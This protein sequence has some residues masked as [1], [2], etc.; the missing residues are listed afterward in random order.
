[1]EIDLLKRIAE[2]S[3]TS[4][5]HSKDGATFYCNVS[6]YLLAQL[7]K[8]SIA[9]LTMKTTFSI[10]SDKMLNLTLF[11]RSSHHRETGSC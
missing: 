5:E 6:G 8:G 11:Y 2:Y 10:S 3:N 9:F 7:I 1:M 4:G